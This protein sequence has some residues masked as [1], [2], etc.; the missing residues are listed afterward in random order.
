MRDNDDVTNHLRAALT[1]AAKSGWA[2]GSASLDGLKREGRWLNWTTQATR[3]HPEGADEL[4]PLAKGEASP[5]SLSATFESGEQP[6][7]TDGAHLLKPCRWLLFVSTEAS[8]VPTLFWPYNGRDVDARV[9]DALRE[10]L[11]T[12]VSGPSSFLAPARSV[13]V[14]RCDPGCMRPSDGRAV[15]AANFLATRRHAAL[16]HMWEGPNDFLLLDNHRT[17]HA[18]GDASAEPDRLLYRINFDLPKAAGL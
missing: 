8:D 15:M 17:L 18:R 10:G 13:A 3:G 5:S 12:V 6:L 2:V 4:R 11:F 9:S 16:E 7:H 1:E 14:L